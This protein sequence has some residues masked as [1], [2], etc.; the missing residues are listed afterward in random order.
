M[1]KLIKVT[2]LIGVIIQSFL[3][4]LFLLFLILS[5]TGVMHPELTTTVNGEQTV[6]SPETAQA[7]F[8]TI[9]AIFFVISSVSDL[10]GIIAMKKIFVNNKVSGVL[11]IIGAIIS[12]N[13][14]TFIA[15]LISGISILSYKKSNKEVY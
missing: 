3:T 9:F 12:A 7:T 15:W 14:L 10:L 6:Q 13:L 5:A 1:E 4:L 11:H 8:V 2:S